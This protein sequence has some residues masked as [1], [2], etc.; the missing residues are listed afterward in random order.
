MSNTEQDQMK[1]EIPNF[2]IKE[3]C[4]LK[5]E[6]YCYTTVKMMM[7]KKL[8][9]TTKAAPKNRITKGKFKNAICNCK[10]KNVTKYTI[11]SK[12]SHIQTK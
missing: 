10:T 2:A 5:A 9:G 3:A 1:N 4:F 6:Q 7:R 8:K 11:D 12:R